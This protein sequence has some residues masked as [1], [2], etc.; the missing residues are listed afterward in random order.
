VVLPCGACFFLRVRMGRL[1]LASLKVVLA[2]RVAELHRRAGLPFAEIG[3]VAQTS[4]A[5][6]VRLFKQATGQT[7]LRSV[8]M[9]G[10][11]RAKR[12]PTEAKVANH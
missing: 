11:E 1:S 6:F 10:I 3:A 8:I 2:N 12:L 4:S 7:S 9:C 5:H